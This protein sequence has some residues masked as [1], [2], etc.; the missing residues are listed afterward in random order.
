[1]TDQVFLL[2]AGGFDPHPVRGLVDGGFDHQHRLGGAEAPESGKGGQ[3]GAAAIPGGFY[4]GNEVAVG[5]VKQG[6]FQDGG[7]E[8]G[9]GTGVLI[10]GDLVGKNLPVPGKPD[11]KITGVGVS[12]T[13]EAQVLLAVQ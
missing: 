10:K 3:V 7:G 13:R 12:F 8:V 1:M 9:K 6:T 2:D 11:F 5:G 4:M